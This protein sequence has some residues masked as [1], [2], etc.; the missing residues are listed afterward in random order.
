MTD[1]SSTTHPSEALEHGPAIAE[2]VAV[3]G[4]DAQNI[5]QPQVSIFADLGA[6]RL[7]TDTAG[8]T[9]ARELL[10]HVP[11]R[12]PNSHEYFRVH[13]D[14]SMV[15]DTT[16]F[17]DK[18]ERE[19]FFVVPEMRGSLLGQT[20]PVLLTTA[21]T[22]QGVVMIFPISLP[23][24]GRSNPWYETARQAAEAAKTSWVRMAADMQLGAYR[25]YKAEGE[26]SDP[27][28]PEQSFRELLEIAFR[29]RIIDQVDHPVMRRLRGLA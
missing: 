16:I 14:P 20:K 4:A 22:R 2:P 21:I 28:W 25:I 9:G 3:P 6:L 27:V 7:S 11:V 13:P 1:S 19:T 23:M 15:F 29:G 24:D 12:K 26:L 18:Q 10:S 8:L 5:V 17:V